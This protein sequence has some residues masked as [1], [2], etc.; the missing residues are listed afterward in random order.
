MSHPAVLILVFLEDV[1]D[2]VQQLLDGT[3]DVSVKV[4]D[5][6]VK[7]HFKLSTTLNLNGAVQFRVSQARVLG[8]LR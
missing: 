6:N 8:C 3:G 4:R 5:T 7:E 2:G 1:V